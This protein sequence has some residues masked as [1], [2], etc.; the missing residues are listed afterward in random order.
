MNWTAGR[1][2]SF[3]ISLI[4]RGF[5][6]WPPKY[7]CLK[8]ASV[9]K[10]LNTKT[11]RIGEHKRCA[12]CLGEFPAKEIQA[13]HIEPVVDPSTGF[14]DWN[15]FIERIAVGIEGY[16]ALCIGC[17]SIKTKNEK[18]TRKKKTKSAEERKERKR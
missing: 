8:N 2:K 9:G 5:S 11:G 1:T 6:R 10:K 4:R 7:L 13:D 15:T 14:V 17:H 12:H 16:Q 3:I 18:D